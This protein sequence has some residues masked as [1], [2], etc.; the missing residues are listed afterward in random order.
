MSGSKCDLLHLL[1]VGMMGEWMVMTLKE[2][3]DVVNS[4]G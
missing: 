4:T 1:R 2:F 3:I